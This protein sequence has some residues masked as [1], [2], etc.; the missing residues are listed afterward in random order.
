VGN[1][2]TELYELCQDATCTEHH[3]S[4]VANA[5]RSHARTEMMKRQCAHWRTRCAHV[6][7]WTEPSMQHVT[8]ETQI[9]HA[10]VCQAH[11]YSFVRLVL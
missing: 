9:Q 7:Q 4:T 11:M 8:R 10:N 3:G 6:P 1:K 2:G 5:A